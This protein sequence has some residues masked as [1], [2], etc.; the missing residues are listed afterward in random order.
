MPS[1]LEVQA[2]QRAFQFAGLGHNVSV[3]TG[4]HQDLEPVVDKCLKGIFRVA[5]TQVEIA[6]G[7]ASTARGQEG[8]GL[9][10]GART[11]SK[12]IDAR[13]VAHQ[14]RMSEQSAAWV[15]S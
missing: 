6:K 7:Y 9:A 2:T 3:L 10:A 5:F 1:I 15:A 13:G 12:A 8:R 11:F 4:T 14:V